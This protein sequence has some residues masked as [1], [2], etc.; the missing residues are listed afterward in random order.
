MTTREPLLDRFLVAP[1]EAAGIADRDPASTGDPEFADL[2][3]D[4]LARAGEGRDRARHRGALR[5]AGAALG[6]RP[7]AL[8]VVLQAMDAAGKD[9]VI[10]HV[11]SGVN[12]QGVHVVSFKQPS[13]EELDHDF[14]WRISKP[15]PSVAASASSTGRT[16]RMSS[17]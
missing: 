14:L 12:P 11:M 1:G 17:R 2:A 15:S 4:E 7:Y 5:G 3:Q 6:D 8:L 10:K 9:S 16:T 13:T